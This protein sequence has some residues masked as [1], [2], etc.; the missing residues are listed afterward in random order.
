M[1]YI[2]ILTFVI[3]G[4]AIAQVPLFDS[5]QGILNL[6][7][8][9]V[10]PENSLYSATLRK[11]DS[12][13][14]MF[15]I[16]TVTPLNRFVA[17]YDSKQEIL[18]L[19]SI[20]IEGKTYREMRL[21]LVTPQTN[22]MRFRVI[23]FKNNVNTSKKKVVLAT[24]E[25]KAVAARGDVADDPA[26][27][28]HPQDPA[29][30]IIIGTQKIDN[31]TNGGLSVYDLNGQEIQHLAG[32][33]M[34]NVDLRYNFSLG[35]ENVAIVAA[36]NRK[37]NS[38]A[39]YKINPDTRQLEEVS[40]R[41]LFV[42]IPEIYGLCMYHSVVFDKFYVFINN[43]SGDV[44]QREIFDNGEG[45]IETSFVRRLKINSQVEG[46]VADDV[47]G[48]LF[49]GEEKVG[50]WKFSAEPNGSH[51][52]QLIDKT[53]QRGGN[54][55]P[56][57]EGL[58]IFY[59]NETEGY[60]IASNQGNDTFTVYNRVSNE[61][62]GRFS[63]G[64]NKELKIDAVSFTDGIDVINMPLGEAF[65]YGVFVTQDHENTNPSKNQNFKLV[66]WEKI[67][68]ALGL[69]KESSYNPRNAKS[70]TD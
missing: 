58:T 14:F 56:E 44:E 34:N 40:A 15:E 13:E 28:I 55:F 9:V 35:E 20:T 18:Y 8:V 50:I 61:Y 62:L 22:P 69:N 21:E 52:G 66:P 29:Q 53:K 7:E 5:G 32:G 33:S 16:D 49:I 54:I 45:L 43:K 41:V 59:T 48:N 2:L 6:P 4:N 38:V 47:F 25:T 70:T 63:V 19:P 3:A 11:V 65:P 36:S 46:C 27:W 10:L 60:I 26:I 31:Q 17:Q 68:D 24:I 12:S 37:R 30:S 1:K 51:E 23:T 67:A 64:T 57:V 42:G 39:I